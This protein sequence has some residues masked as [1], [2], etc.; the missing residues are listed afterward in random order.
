MPRT[1]H[2]RFTLLVVLFVGSTLRAADVVSTQA[3]LDRVKALVGAGALPRK[4]LAD[5]ERGLPSG[6]TA[7]SGSEDFA[8]HR[9][10]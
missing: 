9:F 6:A 2:I 1:I 10:K 5:A 8:Q 7:R 4:A 3:E